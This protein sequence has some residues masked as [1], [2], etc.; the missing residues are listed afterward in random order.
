V[1]VSDSFATMLKHCCSTLDLRT[2]GANKTWPS[3]EHLTGHVRERQ[4]HRT[5]YVR[6]SPIKFE[7]DI[8]RLNKRFSI[9][10]R[11]V[12]NYKER[13]VSDQK[14]LAAPKQRI[15]RQSQAKLTSTEPIR[16]YAS[17]LRADVEYRTVRISKTTTAKQVIMGLL[18]KF[19]LKHVDRNMFFLAIEVNIGEG[20][21]TVIKIAETNILSEILRCN[22]WR[23]SRLV[24]CSKP[25]VCVRVYDSVIMPDSVYKSI[26]V[27]GDTT[28]EDVIGIVLECC[29]SNV[30]PDRLCLVLQ[31]DTT[32]KVL[33]KEESVLEV[34]TR[35]KEKQI[36][37]KLVVEYK[38]NNEDA[39]NKSPETRHQPGTHSRGASMGSLDSFDSGYSGLSLDLYNGLCL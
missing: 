23:D 2:G 34:V 39:H 4:E 12:E 31:V 35:M 36:E 1:A 20:K 21:R 27:S 3:Q 26:R 28:A 6:K 15:T 9:S 30:M 16:V 13:A 24:V 29:S 5:S 10:M 8:E 18:S 38:D 37:Y 17:C 32:R 11:C 22:P 14:V 7:E 25:G 33:N 19:R